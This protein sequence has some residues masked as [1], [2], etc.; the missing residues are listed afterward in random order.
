MTKR[1]AK[2][3]I[4]RLPTEQRAYVERLLRED[5]LTLDGMIADLQARFPATPAAD[6]SRSSLHRYAKGFAELTGRMREI[7][8]AAEALVGELGEGIGE[9]SGALL[10]QA[11]T[12]LATNVALRAQENDDITVDEVRKLAVAAKNALDTRRLSM[13]ERQALRQEAREELQREQ[14]ARLDDTAR[15]QG[16][17]E[18]QVQFWRQ[19]VLGIQ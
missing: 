2:S 15:A 12:T 10:A 16:M 7:D 13:R 17:D 14:S 9:K 4:T 19:K 18:D 8:R 11:V 6:L 3:A 1:R 5:R